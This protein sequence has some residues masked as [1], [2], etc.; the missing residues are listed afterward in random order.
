M[1]EIKH[2]EDFKFDL[3]LFNI[4]LKKWI[5]GIESETRF[6]KLW[7]ETKGLQWKDDYQKRI[8]DN[9]DFNLE[10]YLENNVKETV[11][12]DVGSGPI[13]SCGTKTNKTNLRICAVDP[14]AYIYKT[15]KEKSGITTGL[16]PDFCMVERLSEKFEHNS[17]DIVHMRN[18]LDH[19]Y[20]AVFGIFQLLFICK[21]GGKVVLQHVKNEAENEKYTGF[22]QWNLC[23]E[24][25]NFIIWRQNVKYNVSSIVSNFAEVIV[26]DKDE[27]WIGIVINKRKEINIDSV[28]QSKIN[29]MINNVVFQSLSDYVISSVYEKM[30]LRRR[31]SLAVR[32][33]IANIPL[34]GYILRKFYNVIKKK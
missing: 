11:V 27:N 12:L 29:T 30:N 31:A 22:H 3:D 2:F 15:L 10:N 32:Y 28:L 8:S 16:S 19:S 34:I 7:F 9:M 5:L 20:N 1:L 6:W 4:Y 23:V 14:L 21:I 25:N 18:A 24:N 13:S 26:E 17:F 33:F